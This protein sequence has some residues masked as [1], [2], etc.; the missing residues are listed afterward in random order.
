LNTLKTKYF[1]YT[2]IFIIIFSNC[3]KY[4]DE[5][6][7]LKL[8]VNSREINFKEIKMDPDFDGSTTK[9]IQ[10]GHYNDNILTESIYIKGINNIKGRFNLNQGSTEKMNW[11]NLT[12]DGDVLEGFLTIDTALKDS[13]WIEIIETNSRFAKIRGTLRAIMKVETGNRWGPPGTRIFVTGEFSA[14]K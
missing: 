7:F 8:Y 1:I 5:K 9:T 11:Y 13:S 12:A 2:L 3:R 6:Y 4:D 10:F 14:R